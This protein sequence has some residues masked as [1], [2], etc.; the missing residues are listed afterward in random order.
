MALSIIL[1]W[2]LWTSTHFPLIRS[3]VCW[4]SWSCQIS[5]IPLFYLDT[6]ENE[7][8]KKLYLET[9][10]RKFVFHHWTL[11]INILLFFLLSDFLTSFKFND[12]Y[13]LLPN[14]AV[15]WPHPVSTNGYVYTVYNFETLTICWKNCYRFQVGLYFCQFYLTFLTTLCFTYFGQYYPGLKKAIQFNLSFEL[16][17]LY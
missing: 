4:F 9:I 7:F 8:Y 5:F 10:P 15:F 6:L 16:Y 12:S 17:V 14:I 2:C 3:A 11:L 1:Q 13:E